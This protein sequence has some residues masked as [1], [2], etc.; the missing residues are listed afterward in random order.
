[1][2]EFQNLDL[3][4]VNQNSVNEDNQKNDQSQDYFVEV[5]KEI[6]IKDDDNK[7]KEIINE[8]NKAVKSVEVEKK[9]LLEIKSYELVDKENHEAK[10]I[11]PAREYT[12]NQKVEAL[13]PLPPKPKYSYLKKW[14]MRS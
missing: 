9:E 12:S 3:T 1:M 6:S 10:N 2:E 8:T 13:I 7:V 14:L 11:N 5:D 4:L